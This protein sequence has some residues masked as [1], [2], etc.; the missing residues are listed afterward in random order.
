[1]I[2]FAHAT[3][4]AMI[5]TAGEVTPAFGRGEVITVNGTPVELLLVKTPWASACRWP[6]S[7]PQGCDTMICINDEYADGRDMSWLWDVDFTP[8]RGT[9]VKP[10]SGVRAWDMAL[11]LEYDQVPVEWSAPTWRNRS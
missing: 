1:M 7:S 4:Q 6:R 10:W 2:A 5:D 8:L 11:R 9:G 3:T